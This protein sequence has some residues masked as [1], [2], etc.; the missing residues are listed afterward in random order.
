MNDPRILL[1]RQPVD[2]PLVG[3]AAEAVGRALTHPVD[4]P[5]WGVSAQIVGALLRR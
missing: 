5:L 3:E 4:E 2:Q 1:M